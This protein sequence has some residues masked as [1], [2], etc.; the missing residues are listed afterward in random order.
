MSPTE[1]VNYCIRC[2]TALEIL[3][4]AGNLRP[5]C[6]ACDWIY[7]PDPKVAVA[8]L[9]EQNDKVLL[10]R[11]VMNPQRGRWTLPGG[12]LDAGEDPQAAAA[13]ECREETGLEV[14]V[15]DLLALV[16]GQEHARGADFV[17]I[18]RARITGGELAAGDDADRVAFFERAHLPPLAFRATRMA[19]QLS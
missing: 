8:V 15:G 12:F 18:Y 7:F 1:E 4:R 11:R 6:P 5:T 2:G 13:R 17:L 14:A 3:P 19:L 9:V 16:P 10:A